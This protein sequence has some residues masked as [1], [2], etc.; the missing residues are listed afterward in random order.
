MLPQEELFLEGKKLS[1]LRS[2]LAIVPDQGT[3]GWGFPITLLLA[4]IQILWVA[5]LWCEEL[6]ELFTTFFKCI[7]LLKPKLNFEII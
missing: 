5:Q 3:D 1:K 2:F 6:T 7:F 4:L